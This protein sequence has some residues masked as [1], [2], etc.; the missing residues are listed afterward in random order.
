MTG[1]SLGFE[2]EESREERTTSLSQGKNK[3]IAS[4]Y[5]IITFVEVE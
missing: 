3:A 5:V 4:L 1:G 2:G